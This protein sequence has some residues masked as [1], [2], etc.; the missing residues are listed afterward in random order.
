MKVLFGDFK[1]HYKKYQAEIDQA[2]ARVLN[3][4]H[5]ILGSELESFEKILPQRMGKAMLLAVL[6]VPK[7]FT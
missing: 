2:I 6:R 1:T 4:G 5:F 3:S 7:P